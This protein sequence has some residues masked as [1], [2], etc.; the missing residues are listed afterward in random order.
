MKFLT[1]AIHGALDYLAAGG[2]IALPFLLGLGEDGP[3]ALYL[4]V[5]GGIGLIVYS[6]LTDYAYSAA[7]VIP[8]KLHLILDSLAGG[9]FVVAPFLLGFD[10]LTRIYYIVM[11]IG[12][13]LVVALTSSGQSAAEQ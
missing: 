6:L 5:A 2:L 4:S 7:K 1:P 13:W 12:V 10:G 8:F 3:V 9:A 11:G